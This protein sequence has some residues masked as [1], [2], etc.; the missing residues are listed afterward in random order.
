MTE[1]ITILRASPGEDEYGDP[2]GG[3]YSAHLTLQG[4][5]APSNPEEPVEIG[6]NAVIT[7]GTVYIRDLETPPDIDATDRASIRGVEYEID[8]EIGLWKRNTS[9]AVQFAVSRSEG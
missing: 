8:G 6:R 9:W 3:E 7:G 2:T 1:A 5:F 4:Q